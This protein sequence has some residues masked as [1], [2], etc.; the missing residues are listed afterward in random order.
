MLRTVLIPA[1]VLALAAC[2]DQPTAGDNEPEYQTVY[3]WN[4]TCWLN[5][6]KVVHEGTTDSLRESYATMSDY[7]TIIHGEDGWTNDPTE[8]IVQYSPG[9]PC[10]MK[11]TRGSEAVD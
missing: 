7:G 3:H 8:R 11:V 10:S 4:V 2:G 9:V 5:G 1:F 6:K